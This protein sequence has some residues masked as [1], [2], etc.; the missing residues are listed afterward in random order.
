MKKKDSNSNS[1]SAT[2]TVVA[3]QNSEKKSSERKLSIEE[4]TLTAI[5]KLCDPGRQTI[6]TVYSGF[7]DAFRKYFEGMDPIQEIKTLVDQNKISF[8]FC[9]GGALIAKPGIITNSNAGDSK[10]TLQKM[11]L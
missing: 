1:L 6:H 4:F 11:G 5:D 2:G 10:K 3:S 8:R 9:R 7:N